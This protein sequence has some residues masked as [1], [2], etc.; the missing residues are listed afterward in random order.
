MYLYVTLTLYIYI[1]QYLHLSKCLLKKLDDDD[2][3]TTENVP[4]TSD[5]SYI[6]QCLE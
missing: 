4:S 2:N 3:D 6:L 5:K 1:C